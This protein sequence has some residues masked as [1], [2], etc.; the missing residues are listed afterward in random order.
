M[1]ASPVFAA[2]GGFTWSHLLLGWLEALAEPAR[3][4][5]LRAALAAPITGMEL[6]GLRRALAE[7]WEG[8]LDRV[9]ELHD[10]WRR[11][12]VLSAALRLL[13]H[14]G[15]DRLAARH[16]GER[17][18]TDW[19]HL[20]E[21]LQREAA[22]LPE[23]AELVRWLH[24]QVTEPG[25]GE[26]ALLRLESESN[27]VRI[28]TI[29]K[30]KGL[31]FPIVYLPF[32]WHTGSAPKAPYLFHDGQGWRIAFDKR[33]EEAK[34]LAQRERLSEDLRLLYVALTRA[35]TKLYA[36]AGPAGQGA[37][38]GPLD[39]LLHPEAGADL[40]A[41]RAP[42]R[43]AD[44]GKAHLE[45]SLGAW[46]RQLDA[47]ARDGVIAIGGAPP[48][49]DVP[50]L[51]RPAP[52]RL[53]RSP[54]PP[55][56]DDPWRITSYSGIL[57][58]EHRRADYDAEEAPGAGPGLGR[59]WLPPGAATGN[60]LHRLLESIE[61]GAPDWPAQRERIDQL[62]LRFALPAP[63]GWWERLTAWLDGVLAAPLPEGGALNEL[64]AADRLHEVGF[65]FS[66][67]GAA[68]GD[69]DALL[70]QNGFEPVGDW[71]PGGCL[72]GL[73]AGAIDLVYRREARY[74]IADFKSNLLPDYGPARL[75][76][77]MR[78]RRYDLQYLLYTL[79]LHR[80]LRLRLPGYDYDRHFGGVRY[81]FLRGM[82]PAHPG[83]GV[84]ATRPPRAL[85]EGLDALFQG[86]GP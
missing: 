34:A 65:H 9:S 27:A 48:R 82:D 35:E 43:A 41:G 83:Q 53:K 24:A 61:Y 13:E 31:Q 73:L 44:F 19:L 28:L 56:V 86:G 38:G 36:W 37:G 71:A 3:P 2:A 10:T 68:G 51:P 77:A 11:R 39:W 30:A 12:G 17:L 42:F 55:P 8:W 45:A 78:E 7:D 15:A 75:H 66:V 6:A 14:L 84:Y 33:D 22:R 49:P 81:L 4:D 69:L 85:I 16:E 59:E 57:R 26:E 74:Y 67:T 79:A 20:S 60:F 47:W 76:Q 63:D 52:P 50:P 21:L 5:R 29:H 70:R 54:P 25:G 46:R 80:H 58:G 32:L 18:L 23:P 1:L 72:A 64:Q 40:L 62:R